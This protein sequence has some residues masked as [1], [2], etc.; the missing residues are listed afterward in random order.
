MH[1]EPLCALETLRPARSAITPHPS[2]RSAITPYP[3]ARSAITPHPVGS[4]RLGRP[5]KKTPEILNRLRALLQEDTAGDPM[6]RQGLWTGKRLRAISR[7]LAQLGLRVCPNTVRRLL[8][9]LEIGSETRSQ[10][11]CG[12]IVARDCSEIAGI[13]R[14]LPFDKIPDADFESASPVV[15]FYLENWDLTF[16][17]SPFQFPL[18]V[19]L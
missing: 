8:E 14:S 6:G 11:R 5:W 1:F 13:V 19:E 17:L 9:D 18:I 12:T 16:L 4:D 2:A 10:R 3:S 7:D 15:R